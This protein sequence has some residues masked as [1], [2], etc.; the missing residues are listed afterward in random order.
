[1]GIMDKVSLKRFYQYFCRVLR[2]TAKDMWGYVSGLWDNFMGVFLPASVY[3][4]I[5]LFGP[6]KLLQV[7]QIDQLTQPLGAYA[8]GALMVVILVLTY[9][10]RCLFITPIKMYYEEKKK[11]DKNNWNDVYFKEFDPIE[12]NLLGWG[13]RVKNDKLTPIE[14]LS[15]W[16]VGMNNRDIER[17]RF[18]YVNQY[19]TDA[20]PIVSSVELAEEKEVIF[21][22]A[23][24]YEHQDGEMEIKAYDSKDD[25]I[26]FKRDEECIL[27]IEFRANNFPARLIRYRMIYVSG[28]WPRLKR[29]NAKIERKWF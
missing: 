1:M 9:I 21:V 8:Q 3:L 17:R 14:N 20:M 18:G 27:N 15:A 12:K 23:N 24:Y 13:I 28:K 19:E 29:Y 22:V 11:S 4:F 5:L 6:P 2:Y 26:V 7:D 25:Y 16:L 10:A